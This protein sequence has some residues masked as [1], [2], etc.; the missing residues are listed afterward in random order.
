MDQAIRGI[1]CVVKGRVQ[2]VMYRDFVQRRA[3][4]LVL[5]GF[6]RNESDGSVKVMAEGS[7]AGLKELIGFLHKGS[8]LSRV[9]SVSVAWRIPENK[10]LDF[11]ISYN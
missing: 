2:L 6:V 4:R 9:E 8:F 7:E 11:S 3:K 5:T 1:E 10:F